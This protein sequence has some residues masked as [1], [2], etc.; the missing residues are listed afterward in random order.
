MK[1]RTL[2]LE[3][4][5]SNYEI[6]AAMGQSVAA[7]QPLKALHTA[8]FKGF[9]ERETKEAVELFN[10][11]CPGLN[12]E[13]RGFADALQ[14]PLERILYVGMTYL[15]PNCSQIALLPSMTASG[16]VL[17]A[18][19]YEFSHEAEDFTLVRT[20]VAGRYTHLGTS[21]LGLGRDEGL[22]D[23][24]LSVTMSS[25]GFPVGAPDS[26]RRPKAAGLQFWAVI[27]ALLENCADVEDALRFMDGMPIAY[28][29]NLMLADR[30]GEIALVET[31]DGRRS[32]LKI[33]DGGGR[34][35]LCA[36]NHPLLPELIRYEPAAM[37]HS[38]VRY[39]WIRRTLDGAGAVSKEALKEMLLSKY[40]DGL[41]CHFY[42]EYL[43]T[44][45]SMVIDPVGG[46]IEL[47]WGGRRENGWG[48]YSVREPLSYEAGEAEITFDSFT[49]DLGEFVGIEG[50]AA[51]T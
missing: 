2:T 23:R 29:L 16:G 12:D 50:G 1:I 17:V 9:E 13:L 26:M 10:R 48:T 37:R 25:C 21:V 49:P 8:G 4:A 43:G 11:W 40:P 38:L 44:T 27:R 18:R 41:C 7:I 36:T 14:V 46:E 51:L 20:S 32:V 47:C 28:N 42:N 39:D 45:K 19:S 22:N 33:Q 31:L 6:G 5:G 15:R 24:G 30:K 34:R 35:Y 3:L